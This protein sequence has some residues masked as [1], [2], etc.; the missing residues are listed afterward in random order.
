MLRRH[1]LPEGRPASGILA[2][3]IGAP[4]SARRGDAIWAPLTGNGTDIVGHEVK[5]SRSDVLTELADPMKCE[6]WAQFCT[7]WWLVVS[8]PALVDGLDIPETWG[9]MAPPSGRRTRS[10]TVLRPAP[11]RKVHDS[12][13]AWRRLTGWYHHHVA[14]EIPR[15]RAH[16]DVARRDL[17]AERERNAELHRERPSATP[18]QVLV[19]DIVT[20]IMRGANQ[21]PDGSPSP[22][23]L[24][25]LHRGSVDAQTV[26]DAFLDHER[27]RAV[28]RGLRH[29]VENVVRSW[30]WA[31]RSRTSAQAALEALRSADPHDR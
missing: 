18:Q 27:T 1:Y 9:I 28:A 8:D 6:A 15:L 20:R 21:L 13:P 31:E 23:N 10:M 30:E 7:R 4:D 11:L 29:A 25:L 14:V 24:H 19:D 2:T 17:S 3:E 16:L 22:V 5:V 26:A 12:G